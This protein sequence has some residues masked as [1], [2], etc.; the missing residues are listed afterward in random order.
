MS[1]RD[2]DRRELEEMQRG[3]AISTDSDLWDLSIEGLIRLHVKL[4]Q[5]A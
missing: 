3:F 4:R 1:R 5:E 2:I